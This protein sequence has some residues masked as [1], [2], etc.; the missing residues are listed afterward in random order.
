MSIAGAGE[1]AWQGKTRRSLAGSGRVASRAGD[2][3]GASEASRMAWREQLLQERGTR[4]QGSLGPGPSLL[5]ALQ[6]LV[7]PAPNSPLGP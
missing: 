4:S 7:S 3:G 5:L 2:S 1:Q 6:P